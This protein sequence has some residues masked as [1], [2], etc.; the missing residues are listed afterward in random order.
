MFQSSVH[1]SLRGVVA[2]VGHQTYTEGVCTLPT[3]YDAQVASRL[4]QALPEAQAAV[5]L[6]KSMSL[7][8]ACQERKRSQKV[9]NIFLNPWFWINPFIIQRQRKGLLPLPPE[10]WSIFKWSTVICKISAFS[11]LADPCKETGKNGVTF[12]NRPI[13]ISYKVEKTCMGKCVPVH[14]EMMECVQFTCFSKALGTSLLNSDKLLLIRSRLR[15][16]IICKW[17]KETM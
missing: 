10:A 14:K 1:L 7:K 13:H 3:L 6:S 4:C 16:S 5:I 9:R 17:V 2:E 15:F 8:I 11:N 12:N